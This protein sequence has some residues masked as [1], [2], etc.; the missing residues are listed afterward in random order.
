MT[1]DH[2]PF[3]KLKFK[4]AASMPDAPQPPRFKVDISQE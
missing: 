1:A 2:L 4:I 3:A